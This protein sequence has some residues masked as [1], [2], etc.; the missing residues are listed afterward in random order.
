[1]LTPIWICRR[2]EAPM[3]PSLPQGFSI[4]CPTCFPTGLW[5]LTS[6]NP[7][8]ILQEDKTSYVFEYSCIGCRNVRYSPDWSWITRRFRM[9][10][11]T[12]FAPMT[13]RSGSAEEDV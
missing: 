4:P 9:K 12:G 13:E 11:D 5:V 2:C 7:M 6:V 3:P 1:M 10:T 8:I